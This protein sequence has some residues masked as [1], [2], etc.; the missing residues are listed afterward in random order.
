[1]SRLSEMIRELCPDGVEYR[2]LGEIATNIFRGAGIKRDELTEMGT[3]CVRYGE[4]YTTYGIWFDTCI[5]H[6]DEQLITNPKYFGHGDILFAITGENIEEI[7]K[8]TAYIGDDK[9]LA[10][11]DIVVLQHEQNPKYLSYVLSTQTAQR[12]KNKGRVKSKVVHS[13]VPAIKEIVI[14]VPPL[15]IQNEIVKLLDNFTKLTAELT[16]ELAAELALRKKQYTFYRD[17]LLTFARPEDTIVQTD[18]QTDSSKN[19]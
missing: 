19:R 17:A 3:P 8:S 14:P 11:G 15:A 16:A 18:R 13:S 9:C 7:A 1:M 10:G 12:Q 5:S 4:I 2:K 6:T